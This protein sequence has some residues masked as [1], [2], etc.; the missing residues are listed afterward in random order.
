[1]RT[2]VADKVSD[3]NVT[4]HKILQAEEL[5]FEENPVLVQNGTAKKIAE[6]LHHEQKDEET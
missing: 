2:Q 5:A 3:T 1:M 4:V 6:V